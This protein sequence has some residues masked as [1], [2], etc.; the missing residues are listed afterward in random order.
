[1]KIEEAFKIQTEIKLLEAGMYDKEV[2]EYLN[3]DGKKQYLEDF[4]SLMWIRTSPHNRN[5]TGKL[6]TFEQTRVWYFKNL[7]HPELFPK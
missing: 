7:M 4:E 1:M 6:P 3:G 5:S 2:S